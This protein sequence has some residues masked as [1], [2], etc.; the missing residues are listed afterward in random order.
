VQEL[1]SRLT[2][3]PALVT[4]TAVNTMRA[5]LNHD[6]SKAVRELGV[7]FRPFTD[8]LRAEVQWYRENGYAA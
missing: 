1:Y 6:S 2:G 7:T 8:T 5:R 4:R 3:K